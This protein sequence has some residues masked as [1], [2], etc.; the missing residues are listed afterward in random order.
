MGIQSHYESGFDEAHSS[1]LNYSW[2]WTTWIPPPPSCAGSDSGPAS[3]CEMAGDAQRCKVDA[4]CFAV[5]LHIMFHYNFHV[6]LG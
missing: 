2:L 5:H 1:N 3:S 6:K 4:L